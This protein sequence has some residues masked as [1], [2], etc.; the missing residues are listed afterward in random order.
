MDN[1][2]QDLISLKPPSLP[3]FPNLL[4][5]GSR[6]PSP[7]YSDAIKLKLLSKLKKRF[8]SPI[9]KGV[10]IPGLP[11]GQ[12]FADAYPSPD[13]F[14]VRDFIPAIAV[15][16]DYAPSFSDPR[17]AT[18]S[19]DDLFTPNFGPVLSGTFLDSLKITPS[20]LHFNFDRFNATDSETGL[21]MDPLTFEIFKVDN[22][23]PQ[24][25][26]ALDL[27]PSLDLVAPKFS[28]KDLKESLFPDRI[29]TIKSMAA[30]VKNK[31]VP[32]ITNALDGLF[33][34]E[35]ETPSGV[36]APTLGG[37]GLSAVGFNDATNTKLFPPRNQC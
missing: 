1:D 3:R 25:Q 11:L 30:F 28:A 33:D 10:Q 29:P 31:I 36:S 4:Q 27:A 32:K 23:I 17:A 7:V 37:S 8:K 34:V 35:V 20:L 6:K 26:V 13:T 21:P 15:A 18:F 2:R 22:Y 16:F 9:F 5:I 14:R 19:I 12:S 24:I